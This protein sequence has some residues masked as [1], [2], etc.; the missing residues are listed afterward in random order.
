M[1]HI[2]DLRLILKCCTMYYYDGISQLEISR[3][4]GISHPTVCRLIKQARDQGI[5]KI[6]VISPEKEESYTLLE[7]ELEKRF[8]LRE[9]VVLPDNIGGDM[10][11]KTDIGRACAAYLERVLTKGSVVGLSMGTTL[12]EVPRGLKSPMSSGCVFVPLLGGV[13]QNQADIHP[14]MLADSFAKTFGGRVA[15]LHAPAYIGN[16]IIKESLLAE[17]S[18]Q[19]VMQYYDKMNICIVGI[20]TPETDS[21]LMETNYYL[22]EDIDAMFKTGMVGDICL[23]FF[24]INGDHKRFHINQNIFGM[25][26]DKIKQVDR[27]I[28]LVTGVRKTKSV[29][30]AMRAHFINVLITH[31]SLAE[32]ILQEADEDR[33][34]EY[35]GSGRRFPQ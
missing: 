9:A 20:G 11:Q 1:Q 5:V 13:G 4:L 24:D 3:Q 25:E 8:S 2:Q 26:L 16:P 35:G 23:Q 33:R 12:R 27:S 29:I 28:G 30:G 17:R 15:L 19:E 34:E 22:E 7:R 32:S 21:A 18:V 6:E 31:R 14:N 10:A